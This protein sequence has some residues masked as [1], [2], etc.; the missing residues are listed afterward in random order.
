MMTLDKHHPDL[1]VS[2]GAEGLR[3]LGFIHLPSQLTEFHYPFG[4]CLH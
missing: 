3:G 2:F 4:P 1:S